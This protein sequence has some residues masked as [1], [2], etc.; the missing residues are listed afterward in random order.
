MSDTKNSTK[1]LAWVGIASAVI[2]SVLTPLSQLEFPEWWQSEQNATVIEHEIHEQ[3]LYLPVKMGAKYT[4]DSTIFDKRIRLLN[5]QIVNLK[6]EVLNLNAEIIG[7]RELNEGTQKQ[8]DFNT[9]SNSITNDAILELMNPS[10]SNHTYKHFY[11]K[12]KRDRWNIFDDYYESRVLYSIE[13]RTGERAYYVPIFRSKI[14]I[15]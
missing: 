8:T 14:K 12:D 15:Q 3:L 11:T 1:V 10:E 9:Q 4:K 5:A 13:L 2:M 6:G 7:L